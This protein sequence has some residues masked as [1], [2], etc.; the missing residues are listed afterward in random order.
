MISHICQRARFINKRKSLVMS[1]VNHYPRTIF[2]TQTHCTYK[3]AVAQMRSHNSNKVE[4]RTLWVGLFLL[5]YTSNVDCFRRLVSSPAIRAI[6]KRNNSMLL[7][8]DA[9]S[10]EVLIR[11]CVWSRIP[12]IESTNITLFM[13]LFPGFYLGAWYRPYILLHCHT[14]QFRMASA[15][16]NK[17][18]DT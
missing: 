3:N 12:W 6:E 2:P 14:N 10:N 15:V 5:Y 13:H 8:D 1:T 18:I 7:L 11:L 17:M 16:R 9:H 4:A